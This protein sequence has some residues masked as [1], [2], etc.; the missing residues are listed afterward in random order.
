MVDKLCEIGVQQSLIDEFGFYCDDIIF[1]VYGDDGLFFSSDVNTLSLIIKRLCDSSLNIQDQGLQLTTVNI[2]KT[3]N[4]TYK[5]TYPALIDAIIDDIN[6]GGLY[7]KPV[8]AKVALQLH[9]FHYSP[10]ISR[11]LQLSL[12]H[13]QVELPQPDY[14][15][16]HH[17]ST[18]PR[19]EHYKAIVYIVQNLKVT[20]HIELCVKPYAFKGFQCYCYADFA[21]NWNKELAKFRRGWVVFCA[22]CPGSKLQSQGALSTTKA[23][24]IAMS[25]AL[26]DGIPLMDL[27][28]KM[29]EHK[30][31]IVNKQPYGFLG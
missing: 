16:G 30:F 9:A 23:E 14:L 24:F 3:H 2:R 17:Y 6:I 10:K 25:M 4:N 22:E 8:P 21:G 27:I 18:N 29:R 20:R 1:I 31:G 7:T 26:R 13:G 5:F 19:Q 15:T 28:K 12:S 11:E